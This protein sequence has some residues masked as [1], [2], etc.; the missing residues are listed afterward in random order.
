MLFLPSIARL[1]LA[2]LSDFF[3]ADP[4]LIYTRCVSASLAKPRTAQLLDKRQQVTG[5]A[6]MRHMQTAHDEPWTLFETGASWQ[7]LRIALDERELR[8][9][10]HRE[11]VRDC[12]WPWRTVVGGAVLALIL[13]TL[14]GGLLAALVA[15]V[16]VS[17]VLG[18]LWVREQTTYLILSLWLCLL[19][20]WTGMRWAK[21]RIRLGV[22]AARWGEELQS[23]VEPVVWGTA[24]SLL[25]EDPDSLLLPESFDGLRS[26]RERA[27]IVASEAT[28]V[29]NRK[30][31][32]LE[33]GTIA[34]CGPRGAGKSTLLEGCVRRARFGLV[35]QAPATYTPHDF[36]LALSVKLCEGYIALNGYAVP[37][38]TRL[39]PGRRLLRRLRT[40]TARL[41]RWLI[42]AAPAAALLVLSL[43]TS[44]WSAITDVW[45]TLVDEFKS[46]ADQV[47]S[48]ALRVW[49]GNAVGA[50]VALAVIGVVWWQARRFT[51]LPR[52]LARAR[53]MTLT[54]VGMGLILWAILRLLNDGWILH[55]MAQVPVSAGVQVLLYSGLCI[56]LLILRQGAEGEFELRERRFK[57]KAVYGLA[58][59][60]AAFFLLT[61]VLGTPQILT[62]LSAPENP[63]RIAAV[64]GGLVLM[65]VSDWKLRPAEPPL[66]RECRN[67]LY[68]LQTTQM[69]TSGVTTGSSQILSVGT[70]N[71]TS[72][73][74]IPPNFPELVTDFRNLL[75]RV[76]A[77][78]VKDER[79]ELGDG[80]AAQIARTRPRIVIAIDEV[81]RL[82]SADQ[83]RAFLSEIKAILGVPR[84]HYL[85]AVAEDVGAAFVRRGLPHRDVTDSSLDDVVYVQPTRL[86]ESSTVLKTRAPGLSEPYVIL[87]HALSGGVLRDLIRYGRRI[88]D[89]GD[90]AKSYELI[91][92]SRRLILEELSETLA[93]FRTLLSKQP[94]SP[95]TGDILT[96]FYIIGG[97]LRSPYS[98]NE[99]ELNTALDDLAFHTTTRTDDSGDDVLGEARQLIDEAAAYAYF[100]LT[101]LE[102]FSTPGLE[103]RKKAAARRSPYGSPDSLAEARQELGISPYSARALITSIREAW[104]LPTQ[105]SYRHIIPSPRNADCS[106]HPDGVNR[107]SGDESVG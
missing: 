86:K 33:S 11:A 17:A 79:E 66:V 80:D 40:G 36:L 54:L 20:S 47:S 92:I 98:C 13:I 95:D 82:G 101:L 45:P 31:L 70:S 94:W 49:E 35:A 28:E 107:T 23:K 57:K 14:W 63:L 93:G 84:V 26:P 105:P 4:K 10:Q 19:A 88:V 46:R 12:D 103:R 6:V 72:V 77:Q 69:S 30:M 102:I 104:C 59:A 65:Q 76:A 9:Q 32:Q 50:S 7:F 97:H 78:I 89:M 81:D 53:M 61:S 83:A 100:S 5:P 85:I 90:R 75:E 99:H 68:R 52:F 25:G 67:Y 62:L 60:V 44:V 29:L 41:L 22:N 37:S 73:S 56:A 96:A 42:F 24:R 15:V 55:H 3:D 27:Y 39:S 38:F 74:T 106:V 2:R 91:D 34:V 87:A 51:W 8:R 16:I 18:V 64:L 58:A 43:R 21:S 71:A 1:W 48:P